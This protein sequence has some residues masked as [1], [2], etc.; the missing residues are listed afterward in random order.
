MVFVNMGMISMASKF[1][2]Y[3]KVD[4]KPFKNWVLGMGNQVV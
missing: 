3:H 4:S 2:P 1:L